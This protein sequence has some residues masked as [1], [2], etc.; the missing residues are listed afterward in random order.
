MRVTWVTRKAFGLSDGSEFRH[1]FELSE[2]WTLDEMQVIYDS[3]KGMA[4]S[5]GIATQM[6]PR[7]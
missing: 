2:D 1:P 7:E 3:C 5:C 6:P 4:G